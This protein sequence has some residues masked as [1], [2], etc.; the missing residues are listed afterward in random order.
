MQKRADQNSFVQA[1]LLSFSQLSLSTLYAN[2]YTICLMCFL[3]FCAF[4]RY[5]IILGRLW[6]CLCM[7]VCT[8]NNTID[9]SLE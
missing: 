6:K 3:A 7:F 2:T 5:F 9:Y 1:C 8:V 4:T